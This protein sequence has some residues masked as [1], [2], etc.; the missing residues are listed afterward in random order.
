MNTQRESLGFPINHM[1]TQIRVVL[2]QFQASLCIPAALFSNVDMTALGA[3]HLY[4]NALSFFRHAFTF[5][6]L[7]LA[8]PFYQDQSLR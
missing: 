8:L 1:P 7:C 3:T 4:D 5:A 6:L 2:S